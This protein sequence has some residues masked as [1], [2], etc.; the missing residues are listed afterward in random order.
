MPYI[1]T[2]NLIT[3]A[4]S[5]PNFKVYFLESKMMFGNAITTGFYAL[6]IS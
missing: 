1:G 5:P 3:P 4:Y 2:V 6:L